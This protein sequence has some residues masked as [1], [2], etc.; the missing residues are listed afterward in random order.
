MRTIFKKN[1]SRSIYTTKD[2]FPISHRLE[3]PAP[4]W[5]DGMKR[6]MKRRVSLQSLSNHSRNRI[7]TPFTH[8][9]LIRALLGENSC[10][11]VPN[12]PV[13]GLVTRGHVLTSHGNLLHTRCERPARV[14]TQTGIRKGCRR[15]VFGQRVRQ[16]QRPDQLGVVEKTSAGCV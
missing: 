11:H 15:K 6:R 10:N 4:T 9:L 8:T 12:N 7:I 5:K 1:A 2:P 14:P 3:S 13:L 16:V